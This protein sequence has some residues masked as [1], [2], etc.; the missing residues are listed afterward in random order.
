MS[1]KKSELGIISGL[2]FA[3]FGALICSMLFSGE[4]RTFGQLVSVAIG[5][6]VGPTDWWKCKHT[7][8]HLYI[9]TIIFI[10]TVSVMI[11]RTRLSDL[12]KKYII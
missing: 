6:T 4:A 5:S 10:I 8:F 1:K 9:I 12:L 2:T 3:I 11:F 7:Q